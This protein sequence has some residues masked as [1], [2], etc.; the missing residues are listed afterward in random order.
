MDNLPLFDEHPIM[1]TK[2]LANAVGVE[3]AVVLQLIQFWITDKQTYV[4]SFDNQYWINTSATDIHKRY[5]T[6]WS[7][8]DCAR[9][10][11]DLVEENLLKRMTTGIEDYCYYTVNHKA[12]SQLVKTGNETNEVKHE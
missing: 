2:Q 5:L 4:V 1:F 7:L 11:K 9:I 6:F 10:I 12:F 3:K 8:E